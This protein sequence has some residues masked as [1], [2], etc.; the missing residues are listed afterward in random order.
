[1]SNC[2]I[3]CWTGNPTVLIMYPDIVLGIAVFF[4]VLYFTKFKN[5]NGKNYN[6][7]PGPKSLFLL[8]NTWTY[9]KMNSVPSKYEVLFLY[10]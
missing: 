5:K 1:M 4:I 2:A 9:L 3:N 7:P 10:Q 6:L 8:G